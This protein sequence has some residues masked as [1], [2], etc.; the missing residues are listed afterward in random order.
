V[1]Q[2]GLGPIHVRDTNRISSLEPAAVSLAVPVAGAP[3]LPGMGNLANFF[4]CE[5]AVGN[6]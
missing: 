5:V 3:F 1:Q 2:H 6:G 4:S